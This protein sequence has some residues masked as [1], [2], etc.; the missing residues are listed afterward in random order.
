MPR[1]KT[2]NLGTGNQSWVGIPADL[3]TARTVPPD[4]SLFPLSAYPKGFVPSGTP[5]GL[6]AAEKAGPYTGDSTDEVQ[7]IAVTGSPSSGTFVVSPFALGATA[8]WN[9]GDTVAQVQAKVDAVPALNG[10]VL[11]GGTAGAWTL[12]AIGAAANTNQPNSV[13][14]SKSL[15]GGSSPDVTVTTGTAGGADASS[16]GRE[17]LE[18][19]LA[20]DRPLPAEGGWP[21]LDHGRIYVDRLPIPFAK[22]G[23][24]T[25]G[26]FIFVGKA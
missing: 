26:Q 13:I 8:A 25:N 3:A 17:I 23:H 1:L 14:S 6:T 12:T 22:T 11:V 18:G 9:I 15:T 19:F 16:D 21:L 24:N 4:P 20:I 2:E 5:L 7:T 10:K